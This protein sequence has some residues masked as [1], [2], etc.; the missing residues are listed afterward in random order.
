MSGHGDLSLLVSWRRAGCIGAGS[1]AGTLSVTLDITEDQ[2]NVLNIDISHANVK[3]MSLDLG[4]LRVLTAIARH[5]TMVGAAEELSYTPSA[6]SQQVRRLEAEVRTPVLERHPRGV[7]LTEAGRAIAARADAIA[8]QLRGLENDL[9]D[10]AGARAGTLRLGVFP[11][12]A[13]SML[14]AVILRFRARHPGIDL[15]IKSSRA[16]PLRELLGARDIDL[17]LAWDYP[18]TRHEDLEVVTEELMT[19]HTVLLLPRGH[20]LA[21]RP[22]IAVN[23]LRD[24]AWVV[25]ADAHPTRDVIIRSA[26]ANGFSPIIAVE[27]NDYPEVQAMI[28][29]GL[30]ITMCPSLATQPLRDDVVVRRL[31]ASVPT[32]RISTTQAAGRAPSPA[33]LAMLSTLRDVVSTFR[34]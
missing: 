6:I 12:F 5:G 14:P 4:Q 8:G 19:D 7:S 31:E 16:A 34:G 24:E 29:A 18:W 28:A 32:R 9:D 25:R 26:G 21:A 22:T 13:A 27:A 20:R 30:G 23:E 11:T 17:A 15:T 2:C 3:R 10:L 1:N 33:H